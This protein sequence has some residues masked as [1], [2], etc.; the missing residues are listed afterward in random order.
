MG[1][2]VVVTCYFKTV[3]IEGHHEGNE[4]QQILGHQHENIKRHDCIGQ[5]GE[6]KD[7]RDGE[8]GLEQSACQHSADNHEQRI[9][10]IVGRNDAGPVCGQAAQLDQRIHR[11]AVQARKQTEQREVSH[12]PPV[13]ALADKS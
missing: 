4:A 6:Q 10:Y 9:Q 2:Q 8:I 7:L 1:W 3:H 12:H 5:T 13:C 11:H